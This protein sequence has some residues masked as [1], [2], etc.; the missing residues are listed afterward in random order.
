MVGLN[1]GD[2][3]PGDSLLL[4][5]KDLFVDQAVLTGESFPVAKRPGVVRA[6]A[7]VAARTN[8]LYM[9]TH[10]VNGTGRA[11]VVAVGRRT[12]FGHIAERLR[13]QPRRRPLRPASGGSA[14][15][16]WK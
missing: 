4:E 2:I 5:A 13:L 9:G 1:G 8:V 11:V 7:P 12:E 14:L 15:P 10:V 6:D 16:C 3:I